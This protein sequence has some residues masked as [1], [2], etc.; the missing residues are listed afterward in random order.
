M[1]ARARSGWSGADMRG[2]VR[3]GLARRLRVRLDIWRRGVGLAS[4]RAVRSGKVGGGGGE[5][6]M[7]G[8]RQPSAH[9]HSDFEKISPLRG[10]QRF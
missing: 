6:V 1:T 4:S 10:S 7:A 2:A 3:A 9:P 5:G 8:A